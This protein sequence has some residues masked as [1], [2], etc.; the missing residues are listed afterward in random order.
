[1]SEVFILAEH[2]QGKIRDITYELLAAGEKLAAQRQATCTA[3]LLGN[4]VKS[5]SEELAMRASKV[6]VVE[7]GRLGVEIVQH[8]LAFVSAVAAGHGG[9]VGRSNLDGGRAD[10]KLASHGHT[11]RGH[12]QA[13]THD[14]CGQQEGNRGLMKIDSHN[15]L[16]LSSAWR[17]V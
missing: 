8:A 5:L 12:G 1:M 17:Q 6:L 16:I 14:G 15:R 2:R 11:C 3:V 9:A 4:D 13:T 7:D 10:T